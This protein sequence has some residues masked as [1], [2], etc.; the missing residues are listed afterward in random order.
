MSK[1]LQDIPMAAHMGL[2]MADQMHINIAVH[3]K[4]GTA[5]RHRA[6]GSFVKSF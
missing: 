6:K 2:L 5:D 1:G 4:L 3:P